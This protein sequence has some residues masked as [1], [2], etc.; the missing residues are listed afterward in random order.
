LI[1]AFNVLLLF[2]V[3]AYFLRGAVK[4][5]M[6]GRAER[7]REDIDSAK[8]DKA[9]AEETKADYQKKLD[10]I[11]NERAEILNRAHRRAD[12]MHGQIMADARKAAED[13]MAKANTDISIERANA[14]NE[15]KRQ[16]IEISALIARRFLET[17]VDQ[18][19]QNKYI[20][21]ALSDWGEHKHEFD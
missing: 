13:L 21:E 4:N 6:A 5:F 15:I 17:A 12:E 2:G 1:Q 8:S 7:I 18:E 10:N 9:K 16:I 14:S 3:L 19:A 20:D 11:E